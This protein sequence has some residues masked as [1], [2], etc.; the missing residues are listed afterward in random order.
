M[1]EYMSAVKKHI[2]ILLMGSILGLLAL[3][4]VHFIPIQQIRE[5]VFWSIDTIE[6]EFE[7]QVMIDGYNATL[8]GN[9]TDCLMLEHAVYSHDNHSVLEQVLHMYRAESYYDENNEDGWWPGQSLKD[10]LNNVSQPREVTYG[11]YWHGY[12]VILKPLLWLTSFNTIRLFNAALQ[13]ILVGF[14]AIELCKK[15]ADSLA[16]AFVVSLPFMFFVSSFASLSLSICLYIML[17]SVWML[18]RC[19]EWLKEKKRYQIFFLVIGMVTS[20]FD[21]LTYPL[22]TLTYPLCVFLYFSQASPKKSHLR[23]MFICSA[24]WFIGYGGMWAMK[25]ILSDL[26]TDSNIIIDAFLTVFVRT[27]SAENTTRFKGFFSVLAENVQVYFNWGFLLIAIAIVLYFLIEI[28]RKGMKAETLPLSKGC[29]FFLLACYPYAW[30]F[31]MQNHSEQHWQFT[32][33]LVSITIFA[34]FTGMIRIFENSK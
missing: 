9:F 19:E 29:C 16:K 8:T 22:V 21:F 30:Y 17:M 32:C 25:W 23:K 2:T 4:V 28:F 15:G 1:K 31:I 14:V 10:Y 13:L 12:L 26:L 24:E 27:Q 11:R 6:K 33:R 3:L 20:Y 34:G 7:D 18:L 5:N